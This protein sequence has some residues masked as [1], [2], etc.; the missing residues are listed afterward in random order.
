MNSDLVEYESLLLPS[1]QVI[2]LYWRER[3]VLIAK[4]KTQLP[5][6]NKLKWF[7]WNIKY[8]FLYLYKSIKESSIA[9]SFVL[10]NYW[11]TI[12]KAQYTMYN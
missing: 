4:V 12:V 9:I 10:M 11:V 7:D 6:L 5:K 3:N 2:M 8:T 1:S